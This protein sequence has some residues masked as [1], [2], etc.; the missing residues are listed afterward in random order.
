MVDQ[1]LNAAQVWHGRLERRRVRQAGGTYVV[2]HYGRGLRKGTSWAAN[3]AA[4]LLSA[5][6][7]GCMPA[8]V[9][10]WRHE[11]HT[12]SQPSQPSTPAGALHS[13]QEG[14]AA[15][16]AAYIPRPNP[17]LSL[18]SWCYWLAGVSPCRQRW[19]AAGPGRC[20]W[21]GSM[22]CSPWRVWRR[23]CIVLDGL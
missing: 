2:R 1:L 8:V 10:H 15:C 22:A 11:P 4:A 13:A 21:S 9:W 17:I 19:Q 14:T 23:N 7:V 12:A 16:Q 20:C 5:G 18:Q 3:S 6:G